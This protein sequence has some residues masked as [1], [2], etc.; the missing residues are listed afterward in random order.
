[1][2]AR[3]V[4]RVVCE[5]DTDAEV[6]LRLTLRPA[7]LSSEGQRYA[8]VL[9][10]RELC[11]SRQ[12]FFDAARV[13]QSEGVAPDT[14]L[15][16]GH[17]GSTIIAMH[18]TVGEAARWAVEEDATGRMRRREWKSFED[19]ARGGEG[20]DDFASTRRSEEI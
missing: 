15:E 4:G 19:G 12:P 10:G 13:L 1:M 11:T 20:A 7:S 18:S 3:E 8:A 2:L 17:E 9:D 5:T 14:V 16:T 6:A